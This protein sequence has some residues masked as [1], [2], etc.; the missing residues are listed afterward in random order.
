MFSAT[1][2]TAQAL[3][4]ARLEGLAVKR[5]RSAAGFAIIDL[6]FVCGIISVLSGIALPR[7][8]MAR[9]AAEAA[10]AIGSLRVV[11]SS[12][13]AFAITC[14][15]GFYAPSLTKL[16]TPPPGST[17]GF[18]KGDLGF[19][20]LQVKSGYQFQIFSTPYALA[21][22]TCNTLGPGL[23]GLAYKVGADPLDSNNPRHFSSNAGNVIWE[24]TASLFPGIPESGDPATGHP[25]KY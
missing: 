3:Q 12:E 13:V 19:S 8:M 9:G 10:S 17:D 18:L 21:P 24:D 5:R 4:Q 23:T 20:D 7:L 1:R 22:A 14:G 15:N 2:Y 6:L 11:G 16:A 25:V